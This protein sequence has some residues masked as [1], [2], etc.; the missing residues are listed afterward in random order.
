MFS[1]LKK[2]KKEDLVLHLDRIDSW[3]KERNQSQMS[4]IQAS[5]GDLKK[6]FDRE[7]S[8]VLQNAD[9]LMGLQLKNPN[10]PVR[11]LH[12]M[13]GN[14]DAYIRKVRVFCKDAEFP[15]NLDDVPSFYE[16][17][18]RQLADL[19]KSTGKPY[20][21]LQHFFANESRAI[22]LG[23]KAMED[24]ARKAFQL[25]TRQ[26]A[27]AESQLSHLLALKAKKESALLKHKAIQDALALK[28][29]NLKKL[30]A[31][32]RKIESGNEYGKLLEKKQELA[33]ILGNQKAL[34]QSVSDDFSRIDHSLRKYGKITFEHDDAVNSYLKNPVDALMHDEGMR[35][36][37]VMKAMADSTGL[38]DLKDKKREKTVVVIDSL[39]KG[40][41]ARRHQ[42]LNLSSSI[43]SLKSE[44]AA[45]RPEQELAN[46][47][48]PI[49]C[50]QSEISEIAK[51]LENIGTDSLD[52]EIQLARDA[53]ESSLTQLA[54][55]PVKIIIP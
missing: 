21:I 50:S 43:H 19:A 23:I 4:P 17:F 27:E 46:L 1:F 16:N 18:C 36:E 53:L 28:R 25:E 51:Q 55:N 39:L 38:L 34:E 48:H 44:I 37:T 45:S 35:I 20:M 13:Q 11:E 42:L 40:L 9:R 7:K 26:G 52:S 49:I 54:Q 32:K 24:L 30:M 5:L 3:L 22:N 41:S 12:Y 8:R 47:E 31:A 6:G 10:I 14:R 2:W 29:N 33:S 15:G